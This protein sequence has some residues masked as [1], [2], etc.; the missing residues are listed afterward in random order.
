M[1]LSLYQGSCRLSE[2]MGTD[3]PQNAPKPARHRF[4]GSGCSVAAGDGLIYENAP[5]GIALPAARR[6]EVQ[7]LTARESCMGMIETGAP[8]F[9]L[10][11]PLIS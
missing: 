8:H 4:Q 11:S 7:V 6:K 9:F 3:S 1:D 2:G 5:P 10:A